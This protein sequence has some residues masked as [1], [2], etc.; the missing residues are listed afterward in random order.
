M[1]CFPKDGNLKREFSNVRRATQAL[2]SRKPIQGHKRIFK[3]LFERISSSY[4]V[5]VL[6][7]LSLVLTVLLRKLREST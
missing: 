5:N 2:A 6:K 7:L 3:L 1:I 4:S